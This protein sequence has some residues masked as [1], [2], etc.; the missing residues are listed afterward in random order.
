MSNP[1]GE[2]I[3]AENVK[4]GGELPP[5]PGAADVEA[6]QVRPESNFRGLS[7]VEKFKKDEDLMRKGV[8]VL[9]CRAVALFFSFLTFMLMVT[10]SNFSYYTAFS[11]V[12]T[13]ALFVMVYTAVLVGIK[14]HE[15]LTGQQII[16]SEIGIWIEFVGDQ[17]MA[18][19]LLSAA[20]AGASLS[21]YGQAGASICM[22][23]LT[24]FSLEA[25]ALISGYNFAFHFA[26]LL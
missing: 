21:P 3:P 22:S 2:S 23:F 5:P 1:E 18:L 10:I 14:G 9:I 12:F 15:I 11:Y 26:K 24:F 20:S 25:A 17:V 4:E 6:G 19:L 13:I 8:L 7:S 16:K